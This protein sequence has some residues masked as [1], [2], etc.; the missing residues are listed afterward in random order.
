MKKSLIFAMLFA[1][2][3]AAAL[4]AQ[5]FSLSA[6]VGGL[7]STQF[8]GGYSSSGGY[9]HYPVSG[10]GGFL[11]FDASYIEASAGVFFG[12]MKYDAHALIFSLS[13]DFGSLT[14]VNIGA[15][16]KYPIELGSVVLFPLLGLEY[17]VN[18]VAKDTN[19]DPVKDK[20]DKA[21][22]LQFSALWF[23]GGIGADFGITDSIY[24]RGQ[25]LYGARL[26]NQ[27]EKDSIDA[28]SNLTYAMAHGLSAKLAAGYK[29]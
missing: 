29:F 13:G 16:G 18:I 26:E 1:I 27:Y 5:D 6:G 9:I 24:I 25:V 22:A 7:Y 23:K 8:D 28:G 3:L 10:A 2:G 4:P 21:N 14:S 11:F 19:G 12:T 20:D 15:L 17:D